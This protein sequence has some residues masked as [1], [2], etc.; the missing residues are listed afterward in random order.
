M[1]VR[2]HF[3]RFREKIVKRFF[4]DVIQ[5]NARKY[6]Q[7]NATPSSGLN[8]LFAIEKSRQMDELVGK[9]DNFFKTFDSNSEEVKRKRVE[10]IHL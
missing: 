6:L 5:S 3:F 1:D 2:K 4:A 10:R 8:E 9:I 7:Y